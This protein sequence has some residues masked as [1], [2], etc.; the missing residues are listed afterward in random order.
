MDDCGVQE[1]V[2]V[3]PWGVWGRGDVGVGERLGRGG[4]PWGRGGGGGSRAVSSRVLCRTYCSVLSHAVCAVL[5]VLKSP[6]SGPGPHNH[7]QGGPQ[8]GNVLDTLTD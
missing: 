2:R 8:V 5:C 3:V 1:Q 6:L 4:G 7:R